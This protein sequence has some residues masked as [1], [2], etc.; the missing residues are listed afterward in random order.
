GIFTGISGGATLAGALEVAR[1]APAGSTILCMLPDTGERYMTTPLFESVGADMDDEELDIARST[2]NYRFDAPPAAPAPAPAADQPA[3]A[4]DPEIAALVE[5]IVAD[6]QQP[7]VMFALEWCEFCWAVRKLFAALE[8]PYRSVDLDSVAYQRDDLGG[9]I[10][11]ELA[12]RTGSRTIPQIFV[13]GTP[14]GGCT[15]V[16]DAYRGGELKALLARHGITPARDDLDPSAF[17]PGWI[18]RP[19]PQARAA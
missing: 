4:A 10:R 5:E 3:P 2:P 16:F 15:D 18:H 8:I 14:V 7:V 19:A 1:Q 12:A 11:P 6:P 13:G 9:R 17:L